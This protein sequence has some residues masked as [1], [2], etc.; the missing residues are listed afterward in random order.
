MDMDQYI[1]PRA[2][3][4]RKATGKMMSS[5]YKDLLPYIESTDFPNWLIDKIKTLGIN[6]L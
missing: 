2:V 5:I 4:L 1:S 6:G 3:A